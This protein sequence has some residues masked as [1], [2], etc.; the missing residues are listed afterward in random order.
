MSFEGGIIAAL[1][2][3]VVGLG[4]FL[5]RETS[6]RVRA[7]DRVESMSR[8][9]ESAKEPARVLHQIANETEERMSEVQKK[10]E[11][12]EEEL[13]SVRAELNKAVGDTEKIAGLFNETF[14][15]KNG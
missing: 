10:Q 2:A 7:E 12:S 15:G 5:Q 6:K 13:R 8:H 3:A 14:G 11:A 1:V 4:A 9:A